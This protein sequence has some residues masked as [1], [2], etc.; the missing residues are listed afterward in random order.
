MPTPLSDGLP[1]RPPA[2]GPAIDIA[3]K[4]AEIQAKLAAMKA[5]SSG[6]AAPPPSSASIPPRPPVP[7]TLPS[8][9][10]M[11]AIPGLPQ[12]NV[13][14]ELARKIAEAKR[15]VA[16]MAARKQAAETKIN[17]YL[18]RLRPRAL[19]ITSLLD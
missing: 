2:G 3:A 10:N 14:P 19:S 17:P 11:P 13:D 1:P 4:R 12:P 7:T 18:V 5:A 8:R 9:A 16:E 15:K 6:G